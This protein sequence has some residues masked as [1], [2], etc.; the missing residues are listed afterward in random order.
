MCHPPIYGVLHVIPVC[1]QLKPFFPKLTQVLTGVALGSCHRRG[2]PLPLK[3]M[4]P[5]QNPTIKSSYC[6]LDL[7]FTHP[8]TGEKI[9]VYRGFPTKNVIILVVTI[10]GVR[11]GSNIFQ[12]FVFPLRIWK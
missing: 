11:V 2:A 8:V 12:Q 1:V 5:L 7:G 4:Y 6:F 3:N 10:F 9:K